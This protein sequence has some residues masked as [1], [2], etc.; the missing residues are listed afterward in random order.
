MVRFEEDKLVIELRAGTSQN[1]LDKWVGLHSAL[2]NVIR[3]TD[4]ES[5][6]DTFYN[7]PDFLEELMPDW[8]V[9][10]KMVM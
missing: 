6:C 8:D 2:C 5:I 9:A 3:N 10:K 7:L 4:D 1:A